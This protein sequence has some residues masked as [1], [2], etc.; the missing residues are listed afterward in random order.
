MLSRNDRSEK[1]SPAQKVAFSGLLVA[2][3]L[4]FGYIESLVP[5]TIPVPGAKPGLANLVT[6]TGL[7]FLDPFTVFIVLVTRIILSGFLFGN[8]YSI[9]YSLAGGVLSFA[10]M[11]PAKKS[12]RLSPVG[13]SMIGG[14]FHNIGQLT[15]AMFVVKSTVL[16][17][18]LPFLILLGT[19]AGLLT[20]MICSA[21]SSY[22]PVKNNNS[23]G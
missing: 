6:L 2:L 18:Y 4:I 7:F 5:L 13:V 15:V 1:K 23:T 19:A 9:I 10:V 22:L 16:I 20:G 14:V 21:I 3:A 8:M 17:A 12:K 11:L